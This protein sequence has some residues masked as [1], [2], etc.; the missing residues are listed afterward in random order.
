MNERFNLSAWGLRHGTLVAFA[1]LVSL[2]LGTLAYFKL[3]RAE[4][5]SLTIKVMTI[6]VGWPGA[7]TREMEQQVV[8][9][10]QRTVQEVPHF[11]YVHSYVQPGKATIF[12]VLKDSTIRKA[13]IEA[14]WRYTPY[15]A[16]GDSRADIQ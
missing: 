8:E 14:S 9:K 7:T 11:D 5:P 1:M 6:D 2:I 4:D 10:L 15:P 13:D 12:L 16:A 3:G